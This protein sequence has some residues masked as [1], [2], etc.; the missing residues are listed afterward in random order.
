M[1]FV[2]PIIYKHHI[3]QTLYFYQNKKFEN[4]E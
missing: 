2:L 3:L 1:Q 4:N